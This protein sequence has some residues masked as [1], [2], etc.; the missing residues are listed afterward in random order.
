MY[1]QTGANFYR[2][3]T[4]ASVTIRDMNTKEISGQDLVEAV[5]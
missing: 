2:T 1:L 3:F 5:N 4:V